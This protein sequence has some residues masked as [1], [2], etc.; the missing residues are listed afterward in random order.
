MT[1]VHDT[2]RRLAL[3]GAAGLL[4]VTAACSDDGDKTEPTTTAS[5]PAGTTAP[6]ATTTAPVTAEE[7]GFTF[8]LLMPG[9]GLT[10]ELAVSQQRALGL[11]VA[12]IND[13]GGLLG[14]PVRSITVTQSSSESVNDSVQQLLDQGADIV[15]GPVGSD[16]ALASLSTLS[17]EK[18]VACSGAATQPGLTA[19]APAGAFF[20][21]AL[22]DDHS[23]AFAAEQIAARRDA[24][25]PK[26]TAPVKVSILA[27]DDTY[28]NDVGGGLASALT[29]SGF[30]VQLV[31]YNPR[32]VVFDDE[33]ASIVA[34]KP[35][36]VVLVALEEAPRQL[37]TLIPAGIPADRI[38]GFDGLFTPRL[39]EQTFPADPSSLDGITLLGSTGDR[40][41]IDRLVA[42]PGQQQIIFGAQ[43]YDCAIVAAL[44]A[45]AAKSNE[46]TAF[47]PQMAPVTQDGRT[48]STYAD[49]VAKIDAGEDVDYDGP[50]GGIAFDAAGDTT[51]AR[52]TIATFDKGTMTERSST[53]IDLA[54][55]QQA[56]AIAAGIFTVQ[57]QQALKLLGY[58][59]GPITGVY[60]EATTEAVK[61]LQ[62][63]LGLE[64]TGEYDEATD[65]ALRAKLGSA[66][67][68]FATSTTQLQ[69]ALTDR[70]YYSGPID[71]IYSTE[72][73][74]AV[75]AFQRDL[76]VPETGVL[77]VATIK[78]A[79]TRGQAT[80]PTTVAGETTTTATPPDTTAEPTT[81]EPPPDTTAKPSPPTTETPLPNLFE[82]LAADP[83][84]STFVELLT[85]SGFN[86]D[87][88]DPR[89]FT[90]FAPT[91]DAFSALPAGALDKLKTDE[92]TRNAVL[93]YH[94]VAGR[95]ASNDLVAGPLPTVH[96]AALTIAKDG[97]KVT[98]NGASITAPDNDA[99]NGVFH[100]ID[101]VLEPPPAG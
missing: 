31:S 78:A 35:D 39:A 88:D 95:L 34:T 30:E 84:Y 12:D 24:L 60:D 16:D 98:V 73:A 3:L 48:C 68:T 90:V 85:L 21:T 45:T 79:Y 62:T 49:C 72:L 94:V 58:Y 43:M 91:N 63:D 67:A 13:A 25:D 44:A 6:A 32:R 61:A 42:E 97:N 47:G 70:G 29:A 11:A 66:S 40:S 17:K 77:D 93:A 82:A 46:A 20:R 7:A 80:S 41:F 59:D 57:L 50:S 69:Q 8:G 5:A 14:K 76:G 87:L 52:F 100:G 27:R 19:Q 55:Q 26:P 54:E 56:D 86:S 92:A 81:T 36:L 1:R 10:D 65:A 22:T 101:A 83:N 9:A 37:D 4:V 28:G 75:R 89:L 38:V 23:V 71:G 53:E 64:A 96:G 51:T 99:K 33:V 15:L 18:A 74:D 2:R